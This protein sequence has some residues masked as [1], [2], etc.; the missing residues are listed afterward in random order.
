MIRGRTTFILFIIV[1]L[2][3]GFILFL[4]KDLGPE[5]FSENTHPLLLEDLNI[6]RVTRLEIQQGPIQIKCRLEN[7]NWLIEHPVKANADFGRIEALLAI[8]SHLEEHSSVSEEER[9]SRELSLKDFELDPPRAVIIYGSDFDT[10]TLK[11]GTDVPMSQDLYVMRDDERD[12][13]STSTNLIDLLPKNIFEMRDRTLF[14][15]NLNTISRLELRR[16]GGGFTQISKVGNQWHLLQPVMAR[17]ST[18]KIEGILEILKSIK[19]SSFLWDPDTGGANPWQ[20]TDETVAS[21]TVAADDNTVGQSLLVG[22]V[23]ADNE[24][25][26]MARLDGEETVFTIPSS[27]LKIFELSFPHLRDRRI[28]SIEPDALK[29]ITFKERDMRMVLSVQNDKQ[30]IISEPEKLPADQEAVTHLRQGLLELEAFNFEN[31]PETN[32]AAFGLKEPM[33]SISLESNIPVPVSPSTGATQGSP[34]PEPSFMTEELLIGNRI[35]LKNN[36]YA[37]FANSPFLFQIDETH[38]QALLPKNQSNNG[39]A[40]SNPLYFRD[41]V[42]MALDEAEIRSITVTR[43]AQYQ[44]VR[45]D[46]DGQWHSLSPPYRKVNDEVIQ[47]MLEVV[48]MLKANHFIDR[49]EKSMEDF[50]LNEMNPRGRKITF[51]LS[52]LSGIQKTIILGDP[53]QEYGVHAAIQGQ[54][55]IFIL[56]NT[57]RDL[58]TKDVLN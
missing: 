39:W 23:M 56:E 17:A 18:P 16:A 30:W 3:S 1:C 55:T 28:F 20:E 11:I 32:L 34:L 48:T 47:D 35:P 58:L 54:D 15:K 36:R 24:Q 42:V 21:I 46:D 29:S 14:H 33:L 31:T 12:I 57:T 45:K 13:V 44:M 26:V 50:G 37:K 53:Y 27:L 9:K 2:L 22:S 52:G 7:G 6:D 41:R 5:S 8:M 19:I 40:F 4:D 10:T 25:Q 43:E 38:I 49:G 51:G